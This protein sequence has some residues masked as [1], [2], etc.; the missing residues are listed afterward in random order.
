MKAAAP[1]RA[2]DWRQLIHELRKQHGMRISDIAIATSIA[3]MSVYN[4]YTQ[5]TRPSHENGETLIQ[6]W[7]WAT[8]KTREQLPRENA[9]TASAARSL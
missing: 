9:P 2:V 5:A 6:L 7:A 4:Y 8:S 1:P 3:R